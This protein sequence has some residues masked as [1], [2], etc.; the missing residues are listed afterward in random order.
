V[1][2]D[3]SPTVDASSPRLAATVIL[4]RP[5]LRG[6]ELY[7]TRR[8][9]QSAFAAGAFVFPGGTAD[10]QDFSTVMAARTLGLEPARVARE[11][12]A[13][14][15]PQ[16]P[17]SEAAVGNAAA[18]ALFVAALRELFEEAGI[19]LARRRDGSP[20]EAANALSPD[21]Q[22]ERI[23]LGRGALT[24]AEFLTQ[25]DWF[26]DTRE[27]ALF[28]H[29][30]T[31]PSEPRRFNTHFFFAAAPAGQ[32]GVADA[33]ETHEGMWIAPRDAL[34]RHRDGVF[35][36]VYPTIKHLER[37][38]AFESLEEALHFARSKTVL[39]ILPASGPDGGFVMPATLEHAW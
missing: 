20:V 10:G 37:L 22:A 1:T 32:A 36:L 4:A 11:F 9:G 34:A 13:T 23:P 31:P 3:N 29:W 16:L 5:A 39:T 6:I 12:R 25:R 19:L 8:S 7:M 28:S 33:Y 27:L 30:I 24:F 17:S 14:V 38:A 15:P 18:G 35:H 21:V 26:A 2:N